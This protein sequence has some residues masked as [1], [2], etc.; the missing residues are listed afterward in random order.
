MSFPSGVGMFSEIEFTIGFSMAIS[1]MV[2][3]AK[4]RLGTVFVD[5]RFFFASRFSKRTFQSCSL[6]IA[7]SPDVKKRSVPLE[8]NDK[9]DRFGVPKHHT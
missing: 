7:S 8:L 9:G 2:T 5:V 1:A 6:N 3:K 4:L